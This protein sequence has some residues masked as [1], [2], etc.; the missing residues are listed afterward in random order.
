MFIIIL[1]GIKQLSLSSF[2][3]KIE[4]NT[5]FEAKVKLLKR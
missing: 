5:Y 1:F 2:L 4:K 3:N